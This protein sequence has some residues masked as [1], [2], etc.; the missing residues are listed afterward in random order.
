M[1]I[2]VALDSFKG[3]LSS[4]IAGECLVKGIRA[5]NPSFQTEVISVADGGE[6][7]LEMLAAG[8]TRHRFTAKDPLGRKISGYYLGHHDTAYLEMAVTS[9]LTRLK[10]E[11]YNPLLTSTYGL[12]E[13]IK[14]AVAKGFRRIVIFAGGSATNDA[15][16][17]A[18]NALGFTFFSKSGR[19]V[20]PNGGNLKQITSFRQPAG[21][22][23]PEIT[24]ATDVTNPFYGKNGATLVYA[25][26]K[27]ATPAMLKILE[28]GMKN[29]ASLF[30]GSPLHLLQ[31]SGAAGGL[32]GGLHLFLGARIV[33][34][35]TLLFETTGLEK[36]VSSADIVVTGE[37]HIDRQTLHGKL[38][39]KIL[40]LST[41]RKFILVAGQMT[42]E[43][44]SPVVLH[45][46]LLTD[47]GVSPEQAMLNARRLM[48]S[49]GKELAKFL[50]NKFGEK[51]FNA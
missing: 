4:K 27:G 43:L 10:K 16:L 44:R 17:G 40:A 41:K 14:K 13:S 1:K 37:G 3:T 31:G 35:T 29:V 9:G 19:E 24:V 20:I 51:H 30:P 6:G 34:A 7:S 49:K 47:N 39:S 48:V 15:G 36:K 42:Q 45:R 46:F 8:K 23:L 11:E 33:P 26:Q 28:A 22:C 21:L 12:G 5:R 32:A 2:L 50:E 18:L 38:V 25:A